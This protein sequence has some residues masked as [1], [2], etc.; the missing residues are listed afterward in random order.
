VHLGLIF[1]VC[2]AFEFCSVDCKE[3]MREEEKRGTEKA[4]DYRKQEMEKGTEK[5]VVDMDYKENRMGEMEKGMEKNLVDNFEKVDMVELECCNRC[6][7]GK[8]GLGNSSQTLDDI[9]GRL[10]SVQ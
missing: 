5:A 10:R 3:N 1:V 9:R 2:W 8:V 6:R 4:V 7:V